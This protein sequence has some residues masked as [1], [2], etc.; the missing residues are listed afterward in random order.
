MISPLAKLLH[1]RAQS[2]RDAQ[3]EDFRI[4]MNSHP[5]QRQCIAG[6]HAPFNNVQCVCPYFRYCKFAKKASV[7]RRQI[8][9]LGVWHHDITAVT[10]AGLVS[11]VS[12]RSVMQSASRTDASSS[13]Q[14]SS[15]PVHAC[16]LCAGSVVPA[17]EY[18]DSCHRS[19]SEHD[20]IHS[21]LYGAA[22]TKASSQSSTS[23]PRGRY[24]CPSSSRRSVRCEYVDRDND[25][26]PPNSRLASYRPVSQLPQVYQHSHQLISIFITAR[27]AVYDSRHWQAAPNLVCKAGS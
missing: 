4:A 9:S 26:M 6:L 5:P 13:M 15:C 17:Q 1:K 12:N 18:T 16:Y 3:L 23:P 2:A 25:R 10:I 19:L 11:R 24:I 20:P 27:H 8:A 22:C 14:R 7:T 21:M